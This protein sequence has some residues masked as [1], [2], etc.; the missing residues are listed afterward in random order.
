MTTITHKKW[1]R[2]EKSQ[3]ILRFLEFMQAL[4]LQYSDISRETGVTERTI[5][6]FVWENKS[7]GGQLLRQIHMKFGVS[8]DWILSGAGAMFWRNVDK[9]AEPAGQY[10]VKPVEDPRDKR[11][12]TFVDQFIR[13]A[14]ADEKAWLE[15]QLK[16]HVPQYVK[17]LEEHRE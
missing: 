15:I 4:N 12:L 16:L 1:S 7:L 3:E 8:L 9:S 14:S 13:S 5:T 17:F 10:D 11:M 6:S 2:R